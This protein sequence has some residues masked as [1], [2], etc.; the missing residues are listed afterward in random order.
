MT[1]RRLMVPAVAALMV[2]TAACG[3][4]PEPQPV[5]PTGPT[6]EEL[7]AQARADSIAAEQARLEEER[8]EQ[9]RLEAE[10]R[11][12]ERR[13]AAARETLTETIFFNYDEAAITAEGERTLRQ[14][15]DILRSSPA[16]RIRIEGHADERGSNEYNIA[17]GNRRAESVREFLTGFG[18]DESRISIV[19]Y[20]EDRPAAI[21]DSE[22]VWA[23]NRRAEFVITAG[24]NQ[25]NPGM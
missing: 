9:A 2:F 1:H 7:A 5:E 22:A 19:S 4:D 11:E 13:M 15:V 21:G 10:Q 14:K 8:R 12:A 25:I 20:G 18:I 16:V 3:S 6:A 23:Q 17:L 24:A